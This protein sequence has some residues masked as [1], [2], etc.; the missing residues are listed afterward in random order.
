[1]TVALTLAFDDSSVSPG[2]LGFLVVAALGVATYL[3]I[4][5]MNHQMRKIDFDEDAVD[6][7]RREA[8]ES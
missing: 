1:M 5:S 8:D 2:V 7:E 3:L 6:K 4:R